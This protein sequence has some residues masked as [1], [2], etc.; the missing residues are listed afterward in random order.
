MPMLLRLVAETGV[1]EMQSDDVKTVPAVAHAFRQVDGIIERNTDELF[2]LPPHP[3]RLA[4]AICRKKKR[5]LVRQSLS[6][7]HVDQRTIRRQVAQIGL[8]K[9]RSPVVPDLDNH[10]RGVSF[11]PSVKKSRLGPLRSFPENTHLFSPK[12]QMT[13]ETCQILLRIRRRIEFQGLAVVLDLR[14][15]EPRQTMSVE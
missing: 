8:S 4:Q 3:G 11:L 6:S 2:A 14:R 13:V 12:S 10:E 7:R 1:F 15:A 5:Y 9:Q